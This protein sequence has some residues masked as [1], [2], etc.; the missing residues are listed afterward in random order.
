MIEEVLHSD[1]FLSVPE[2]L[3]KIL[4][5]SSGCK[6]CQHSNKIDNNL[7]TLEDCKRYRKQNNEFLL[8]LIGTNPDFIRTV[9]FDKK[10]EED[11][12]KCYEKF[13]FLKRITFINPNVFEI[14]GYAES[15]LINKQ[16]KIEISISKYNSELIID[17]H[18]PQEYFYNFYGPETVNKEI[19]T[20]DY[21]E[22]T[23]SLK[24][25]SIPELYFIEDVHGMRLSSE[26]IEGSKELINKFH[27]WI[28]TTNL[29][30]IQ[31]AILYLA[32]INM[33]HSYWYSSHPLL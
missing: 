18:L 13:P 32:I 10:S 12:M 27:D 1:R 19:N 23:K 6:F 25:N 26:G 28:L 11:Y 30:E 33:Y 8:N 5:A 22:Y 3:K 4:Q 24:A 14:E 29:H 17:A 9:L 31:K 2:D 7:L 15:F 21:S 16:D 20:F